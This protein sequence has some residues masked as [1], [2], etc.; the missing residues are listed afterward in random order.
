MGQEQINHEYAVIILV[1]ILVVMLIAIMFT[2][3]GDTGITNPDIPNP[4]G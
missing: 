2:M 1:M 3:T 4:F